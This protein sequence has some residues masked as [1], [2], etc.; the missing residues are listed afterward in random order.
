MPVGLLQLAKWALT[1][2]LR[3]DLVAPEI[4]AGPKP[5]RWVDLKVGPEG[6]GLT[7]GRASGRN[8]SIATKT[9]WQVSIKYLQAV[10]AAV[11][12]LVT[13]PAWRL[14]DKESQG[15]AIAANPEIVQTLFAWAHLTWVPCA[16]RG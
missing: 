3:D 6:G 8:Q 7:S 9:K 12:Q 1:L 15:R 5:W 16:G 10:P 4:P 2:E 13:S 14:V 11:E